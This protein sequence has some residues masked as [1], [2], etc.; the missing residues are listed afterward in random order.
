MKH[1]LL[2]NMRAYICICITYTRYRLATTSHT[3]S[4][5]H[6]VKYNYTPSI[7]RFVCHHLNQVTR[8][9]GIL[10]ETPIPRAG[11]VVGDT[12]YRSDCSEGWT[13]EVCLHPAIKQTHGGNRQGKRPG[14]RWRM[15]VV[16]IVLAVL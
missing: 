1:G 16:S 14:H 15:K 8:I 4:L 6:T 10:Q 7:L 13:A 12:R 5:L 3:F 2:C 9:P 11:I